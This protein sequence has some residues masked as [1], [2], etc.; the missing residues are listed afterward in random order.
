[1]RFDCFA[2]VREVKGFDEL[3][4]AVLLVIDESVFTISGTVLTG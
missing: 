2:V 3:S 4:V 1:M